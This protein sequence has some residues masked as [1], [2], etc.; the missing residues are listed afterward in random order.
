MQLDYT[1][2]EINIRLMKNVIVLLI[3]FFIKLISGLYISITIC[4]DDNFYSIFVFF[5]V[6]N[7]RKYSMENTQKYVY[8]FIFVLQPLIIVF[9]DW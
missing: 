9:W 6:W 4:L 3:F 7:L 5:H 8:M 2:L 1:C